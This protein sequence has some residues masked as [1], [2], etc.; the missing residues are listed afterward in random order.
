MIRYPLGKMPLH[1]RQLAISSFLR[2]PYSP[3]LKAIPSRHYPRRFIGY[4]LSLSRILLGA[5]GFPKWLT[6]VRTPLRW[7]KDRCRGGE[8]KNLELNIL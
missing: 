6:G 1:G 3:P 7:G 2:R 4:D 5:L 8:S